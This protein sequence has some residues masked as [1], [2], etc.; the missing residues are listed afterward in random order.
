LINDASLQGGH[1]ASTRP[2]GFGVSDKPE[3][4][5]AGFPGRIFGHWS[6]TK[7][8]TTGNASS[9]SCN[10]LKLLL[11]LARARKRFGLL[12]PAVLGVAVAKAQVQ[13]VAQVA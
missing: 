3:N 7:H 9:I 5:P 11:Y 1:L 2:R 4:A 12:T 6:D 13:A 8:E 10:R